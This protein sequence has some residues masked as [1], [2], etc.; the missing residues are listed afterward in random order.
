[1]KKLKD[2]KGIAL[3]L[4]FI[5]VLIVIV[6]IGIGVLLFI[7]VQKEVKNS[8]PSNMVIDSNIVDEPATE[9]NEETDNQIHENTPDNPQPI[10]KE[11]LLIEGWGDENTATVYAVSVGKGDTVPVPKGFYYVGGDI[12]TGVIISD[13]EKDKYEAGKDKTKFEYT[14][15]LKGNQFVWIPCTEEEYQKTDMWYETKQEGLSLQNADW[16]KETPIGEL[17]QIKKYG[18]FYVARYEAGLADT[19][20]EFAKTQEHTGTNK[21]YNVKGVPQSKEG[22][23][24]W[25]FIDYTHVKMNAENMYNNEYVTSSLISGTQWDV[26]LNRI[27]QKRA[28][29]KENLTNSSIW[30]NYKDTEISYTGRITTL[31]FTNNSWYIPA[32]SGI[33]TGKTE[34]Y[35][36]TLTTT[37][38]CSDTE[39]YHIFDLAGN[40]A[41]YTTEK[42][43]YRQ[44]TDQTNTQYYVLRGGGIDQNAAEYPACYRYGISHPS[45]TSYAIGFRV[46]LNMI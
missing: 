41:E 43:A 22:L 20:T 13:N 24:P 34:K 1:M 2:N 6:V 36:A 17:E 32:F 19:I 18:G 7:E 28:I 27:V 15:R 9:V 42:S 29:K 21:I 31:S 23:S 40:V 14:T 25:I 12:S 45:Y 37:G 11:V 10:G 33:N 4:L 5:I 35:I 30:G 46:V 44:E 26:I 38:A 3:L 16:D 39:R 8:R